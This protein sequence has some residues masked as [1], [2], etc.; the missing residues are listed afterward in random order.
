VWIAVDEEVQA[1]AIFF[2]RPFA[3]PDLPSLIIGVEVR[4]AECRPTA[5][6][7]ALNVAAVAMAFANGRT[8]IWAW[9]ALFAH[10]CRGRK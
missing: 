3:S 8:A 1:L 9:F 7:T 10:A 6:R 2:A 4:A 5:M